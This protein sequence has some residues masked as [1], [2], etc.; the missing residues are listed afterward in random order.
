MKSGNNFTID[1]VENWE[2]TGSGGEIK[3][4]SITQKRLS[5]FSGSKKRLI[6]KSLSLES[7]EAI[8]ES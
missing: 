4:I 6:V 7:V 2:V 1:G 8:V 5:F 3:G